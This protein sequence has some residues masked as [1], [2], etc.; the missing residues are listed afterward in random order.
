MSV[1]TFCTIVVYLTICNVFTLLSLCDHTIPIGCT[2]PNTLIP[3]RTMCSCCIGLPAVACSSHGYTPQRKLAKSHSYLVYA[4][5]RYAAQLCLYLLVGSC[6]T[7][8]GLAS[9]SCSNGTFSRKCNTGPCGPTAWRVGAW[10]VCSKTCADKH[11]P[12][13]QTRTVGCYQYTDGSSSALVR[14][15][16]LECHHVLPTVL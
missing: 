1:I 5:Q 9:T 11:G 14:L 6:V 4:P 2:C 16:I 13:T 3:T 8:S 15:L 10:G 7:P 12:G